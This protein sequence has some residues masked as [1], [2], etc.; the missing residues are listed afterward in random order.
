MHDWLRRI[1]TPLLWVALWLA[2]TAFWWIGGQFTEEPKSLVLCAVWGGVPIVVV[3]L[4]E[5]FRSFAVGDGVGS[6]DRSRDQEGR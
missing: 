3:M 5:Y 1:P 2:M 6:S 4:R